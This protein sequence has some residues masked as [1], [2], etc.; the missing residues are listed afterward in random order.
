MTD[1]YRFFAT[2]PKGIAPL[3]V[4]ELSAMGAPD[5]AERAAGVPFTG[6]LELAYRAC[7][8]SR[9]ANRVLLPLA[10]FPAPT[11][12]A[13]YEAVKAIAWE[14]HLGV[15]GTLAVDCSL[16]RAAITHS[17]F[18]A[19]RVKD[20][21]VDRFRDACGA[22]PSVDVQRPDLRINLYVRGERATVSVDLSGA[23][24]HLRGYRTAGVAAPLKEN[25][26]AAILLRAGW[27][28]VA[29]AGGALVDPLCG[30]GTLPIE[31]AMI[32]GDIA[33]GLLRDYFGFLGWRGH[34]PALWADLLAEAQARRAAGSARPAPVIGYDADA[35]AVRAALA[36][37][38]Q[39]GLRGRVHIE[40]RA[41]GDCEPPPKVR[42]P[43]LVVAN[44]PYGERLGTP[45]LLASLYAELGAL[46]RRRFAGWKAA[47]FTANPELG[48]RIGLRARRT[49][50][51]YNGAMECRLLHFVLDEP[52]PVAELSAGAEMFANRLR[53]NLNTTGRWARREGID[54]YRLYDAD[55]PEYALA[56][57]LYGD[58]AE[59]WAHVQEYEAPSSV[60]PAKAGIRLQDALGVIPKV[61]ELPTDHV[62]FKVRRRQK[63]RDQYGKLSAAGRFR[64]VR[65]GGLRFLVN[66]TDYLDT[67]LF[68]DHRPIRALIRQ[69]AP[70][71]RFL[72]LFGYT[73]SATVC[74]AAGGAVATTTVDLSRTYLDWAQRNL[75]LNG[76][77]G[78]DHTLVQAD[79][80][81]WLRAP[82]RPGAFDLIFLDPPTFS[83]SK[84]MSGT[85]DV[86][87]DHAA[88]IQDALR[89]LAPGGVLLFSTN[90][91]R[92][93]LDAAALPGLEIE[94]ISRDTLPRDYVRSPRIHQCWRITR[95]PGG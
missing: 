54:C 8:W 33:P 68:L 17:Q 31:A 36:N 47:V 25:L 19:L 45:A 66:F 14:D 74:A 41:L 43:G 9:T 81:E 65:A 94:D 46:L 35:A 61:L 60:D 40:R 83:T 70:G 85:F 13:L 28:E 48:R 76:L 20:A 7:L 1:S 23:S 22:R 87:R 44:P 51:L 78:A 2:A 11:P 57:D 27:A 55:L 59:R 73:G 64:E 15:D 4:E 6:D 30:S 39:A 67:G 86:Q 53:K 29:E 26:A 82:S 93:R 62:F 72:N 32:A 80:L 52:A 89:W 50:T 5:A 37:V 16:A 75:A 56:I 71:R 49:H 92:F 95:P 10:E 69:L 84:R 58:G 63:G 34:D 90:F 12:D 42:A 21:V 91:R 79:C 18:A 24:L 77:A 3:L 88:L 38:A